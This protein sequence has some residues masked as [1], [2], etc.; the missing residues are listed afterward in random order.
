M[1]RDIFVEIKVSVEGKHV[2]YLF[3]GQKLFVFQYLK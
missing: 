2:A 1:G 3:F